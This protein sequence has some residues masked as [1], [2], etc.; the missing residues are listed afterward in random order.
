MPAATKQFK[1]KN[2]QKHATRVEQKHT[3]TSPCY[4]RVA[5]AVATA[6]SMTATH[7]LLH[8]QCTLLPLQCVVASSLAVAI[9]PAN[10]SIEQKQ[11]RL[12]GG[13]KK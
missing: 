8:A 2:T 9:I 12:H 4:V 10:L 13:G 3:R 6:M 5:A 1:T 11:A 7:N